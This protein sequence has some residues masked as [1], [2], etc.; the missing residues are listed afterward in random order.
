MLFFLFEMEMEVC[1][2]CLFGVDDLL[3]TEACD[4]E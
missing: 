2:V 3:H 4:F 1:L